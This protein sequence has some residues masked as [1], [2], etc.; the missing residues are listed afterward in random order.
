MSVKRDNY[1]EE[2]KIIVIVKLIEIF[3]FVYDDIVLYVESNT[4][5]NI[6][7]R[8]YIFTNLQKRNLAML[9]NQVIFEGR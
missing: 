4:E 9:V 6:E 8:H 1:L 7:Y 3:I 5:E 2:S